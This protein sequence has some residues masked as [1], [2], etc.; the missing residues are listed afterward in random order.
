MPEDKVAGC[1]RRSR[2]GTKVAIAKEVLAVSSKYHVLDCHI[3]MIITGDMHCCGTFTFK[4]CPTFNSIKAGKEISLKRSRRFI[5]ALQGS[6]GCG[7]E[8]H[9]GLHTRWAFSSC[10]QLISPKLASDY[11][12][13]RDV[14]R[15]RVV[16]SDLSQTLLSQTQWLRCEHPWRL[17][18]L[19]FCYKL[20]LQV[21]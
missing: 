11:S 17:Q 7:G 18:P 15:K 19:R 20:Y 9:R 2:W 12:G 3:S 4:W 13:Y 8:V 10:L 14:E 1:A 6:L 21:D 16:L 5:G